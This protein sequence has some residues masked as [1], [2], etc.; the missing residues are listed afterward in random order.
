MNCIGFPKLFK[1]NQTQVLHEYDATQNCLKLLICTEEGELFG[2]PDFGV[3]LR[4][5]T[6]DPNSS[7]LRDLLIDELFEKI[8]L[9]CPQITILRRSDIKIT[10]TKH[11]INI[12]INAINKVDYSTSTYDL[13]IFNEEDKQ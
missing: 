9:F 13:Q 6:F 4:R 8:Q 12:K 1:G 3:K 11:K 7:M 10:Q 2:D 5:Y